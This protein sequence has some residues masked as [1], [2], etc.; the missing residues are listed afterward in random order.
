MKR[1]LLILTATEPAVFSERAATEGG[2]RTLPHPTGSALLGWAASAGRYKDLLGKAFDIF[3][4]GRV[5]FSNA[6]P[7]T[8]DPPQTS[9]TGN[10]S[11]ANVP[12]YPMPQLLMEPKH[13]RGGSKGGKLVADVVRV[14]RTK[15]SNEPNQQQYEPLS[16]SLFVTAGGDIIE[17]GLGSRLR[18]AT[19]EGR[20]AEG[21][22]FG[23]MHIEPHSRPSKHRVPPPGPMRYAATIEAVDED[24]LGTDEW[25]ILR[26]AFTDRSLRIGRAS[27][28]YYGGAYDCQFF[29]EEG[30]DLWPPGGTREGAT[31]VRVWALSDLA[32]V[33]GFGS[34]CFVPTAEMLGL[35]QGGKLEESDSAIS[36]RRYAPWN[37]AVAR[38]QDRHR[39]SGTR[40]LERQVI[41]AGSVLSFRYDKGAP[42]KPGA[43]VVGLWGEAGLGRIWTA[44]PLLQSNRGD[45]IARDALVPAQPVLRDL[46]LR[47]LPGTSAP[48]TEAENRLLKWLA[49]PAPD[50]PERPRTEAGQ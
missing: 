39:R 41:A 27:G 32:L 13:L 15:S 16:K 29:D 12:A 38:A 43:G 47:A 6:L 34:P 3:H 31:V 50:L 10:W 19:H 7:L 4:S 22:L 17:P 49:W 25:E 11:S 9:G 14:G 21:Q 46:P 20:A 40:D 23:Y 42:A 5:R 18:T 26:T 44:P 28:T 30:Q 36:V 8:L 2:H 24:V 1:A 33:D 35:P 48:M 45:P 37:R